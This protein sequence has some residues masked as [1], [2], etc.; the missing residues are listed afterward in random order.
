M[1]SRSDGGEILQV[2]ASE[3]DVRD[4]DKLRPIVNRFENAFQRNG[5]PVRG[6]D[7][8]D[9]CSLARKAVVDVV[10]RRESSDRR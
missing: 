4:A 8:D 1:R 3:G 6:G 5:H 7:G 10:V 2:R 9:L